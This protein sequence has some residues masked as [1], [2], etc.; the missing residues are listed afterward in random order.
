MV[1]TIKS[2]L[3]PSLERSLHWQIQEAT[4]RTRLEAYAAYNL[5]FIGTGLILQQEI[6]FE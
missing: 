2:R 6:A 4:V 1:F 3:V 5:P